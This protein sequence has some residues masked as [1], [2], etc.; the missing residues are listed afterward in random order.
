METKTRFCMDPT[1]RCALYGAALVAAGMRNTSIVVHSPQG[2]ELTVGCA[3]SYLNIDYTQRFIACSRLCENEIVNGGENRLSETLE[4]V[5]DHYPND[6]IVVLSA[7]ASEI[8]GDDIEAVCADVA[9]SRKKKIIPIRCA[10]FHGNHNKGVDIA[11]ET[12]IRCHEGDRI[13]K[14][15]AVNLIAPFATLNPG[16]LGDLNW[17]KSILSLMDVEINTILSYGADPDDFARLADAEA[18]ILLSHDCGYGVAAHLRQTY[19]IPLL[20]ESL[21]LPLGFGGIRRWLNELSGCFDNRKSVKSFVQDQE[22]RIIKELTL[23][24]LPVHLFHGH[25]TAI[26]GDYSIGLGLLGYL[27]E[28]LEMD[29]RLFATRPAGQARGPA[30]CQD[31]LRRNQLSVQTA[32]EID[33]LNAG[34]LIGHQGCKSIMG[35]EAE[36]HIAYNLGIDYVFKLFD[37]VGRYEYFDY[38]YLGYDGILRLMEVIVGDWRNQYNFLSKIEI[39][40]DRQKNDNSRVPHDG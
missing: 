8:I 35:S 21:P 20:C 7:C 32:T 5:I 33:L 19:G 38:P 36:E 15:R 24:Y 1:H 10:G 18:N 26:I 4:M 25:E 22:A 27:T 6:N 23:R 30:I 39:Y 2:C 11:L 29:V 13:N 34:D 40:R 28:D 31:M 14:R 9:G 3:Y 17:I 37:K 12:L 16:W